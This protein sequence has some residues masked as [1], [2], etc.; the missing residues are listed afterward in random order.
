MG[1]S[2]FDVAHAWAHNLD[3]CISGS[4][5]YQ[6]NGKLLSYSTCIG[7]RLEIGDKIVFVLNDYSF[8][9]TTAK[10]QSLMRQAVPNLDKNVH[11]FTVK[12]YNYGNS[13]ILYKRWDGTIENHTMVEFGLK[14]L[15]DEFENCLAVPKAK[16]KDIDFTYKGFNDMQR[17]FDV[18][19]C[20]TIRKI[21]KMKSDDFI[22][23]LP[24]KNTSGYYSFGSECLVDSKK[25]KKFLRL[26]SDGAE[27]KDIVDAINGKGT[28]QDYLERTDYLR[29]N[30]KNKRL[31]VWLG[32]ARN[33]MQQ[34]KIHGKYTPVRFG[35]I[36]MSIRKKFSG[37]K[38]M[39]YLLKEKHRNEQVAM[40][41]HWA[42][43]KNQRIAKSINKL[44]RH[45]GL[46]GWKNRVW[47]DTYR[48]FSSFNYNGTV[49]DFT[50]KYWLNECEL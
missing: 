2:N 46:A 10:H 29:A 3:K 21:L 36:T 6:S 9:N 13:E 23:L 22:K 17:W 30:E 49:F 26:M 11:I 32:Y 27:I 4:S 12:V 48:Q 28:Y 43:E 25:F 44:K 47:Q 16:T 38:W 24:R 1:Y 18:T 31:T 7:Q 15:V 40:E 5:L 34:H 41:H 19:G 8:S 42:S 45:C 50:D 35:S 14:F 33:G 20:A 37:D 39:Q